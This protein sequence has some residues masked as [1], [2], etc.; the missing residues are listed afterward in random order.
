MNKLLNTLMMLGLFLTGCEDNADDKI[1]QSGIEVITHDIT[2]DSASGFFYNLSSGS[3]VDSSNTWHISF[4]MMP[5]VENGMTYMMPNFILSATAYI[6]EY[7]NVTFENLNDTPDSF[8]S[9]YFQD[10]SVLQYEGPN[11]II[12][13]NRQT[14]IASI[15]DPERVFVIYELGSHSTYKL[16]FIQYVSG[17]IEFKYE[18][19]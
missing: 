9:D 7:D 16:Q 2:A 3:E 15:R 4:Q 6:A 8:M 17:I 19:L 10:N 18:R 13:Y 14:H 11:E 1:N 5:E 12:Q